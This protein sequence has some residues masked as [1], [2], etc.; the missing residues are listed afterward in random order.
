M[1]K[2]LRGGAFSTLFTNPSLPQVFYVDLKPA[3][4]ARIL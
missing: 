1:E 2:Q 4:R 3:S